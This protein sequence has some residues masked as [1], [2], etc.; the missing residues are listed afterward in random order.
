MELNEDEI[1]SLEEII[2]TLREIIET[3]KKWTPK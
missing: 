1:K 2:K 3:A